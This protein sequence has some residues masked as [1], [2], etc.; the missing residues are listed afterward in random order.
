MRIE[1]EFGS[2]SSKEVAAATRVRRNINRSFAD[3]KL[4][5]DI[6]AKLIKMINQGCNL[7][8]S[9]GTKS[10]KI[11]LLNFFVSK[12]DKDKRNIII[13][14]AMEIDLP[15]EDYSVQFFVGRN[16]KNPKRA[17]ANKINR[18]VRIRPDILII[19]EISVDNAFPAL[20]LFNMGHQGSFCAIHANNSE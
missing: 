9:G 18:I 10:G 14:D 5:E 1:I 20:R 19:G 4:P 13:E 3:F 2:G 6:V 8:I 15:K 12:T 16:D 17:F 11:T 7:M